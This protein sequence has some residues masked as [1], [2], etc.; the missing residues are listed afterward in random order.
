MKMWFS[1]LFVLLMGCGTPPADPCPRDTCPV[2]PVALEVEMWG[3]KFGL[4]AQEVMIIPAGAEVCGL[5]MATK[6]VY[7]SA[8]A[9]FRMIAQIREEEEQKAKEKY[10]VI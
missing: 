6:G 3:E 1:I 9:F 5:E 7:F 4:E 8:E 10:R 2:A